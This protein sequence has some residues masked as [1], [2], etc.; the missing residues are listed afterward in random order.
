MV[1]STLLSA[2]VLGRGWRVAGSRGTKGW[3]NSAKDVGSQPAPRR[4]RHAAV[5]NN[6]L[7]RRGRR[8]RGSPGPALPDRW[9]REAKRI[10]P[11]AAPALTKPIAILKARN[12]S[13]L[14]PL[15]SFTAAEALRKAAIPA[16]RASQALLATRLGL[17][18]IRQGRSADRRTG[19]EIQIV[20]PDS[21]DMLIDPRQSA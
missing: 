15:Q 14:A 20:L 18:R 5:Q 12:H 9:Q 19:F 21:G 2:G 7:L 13:G 3:W 11:P 1:S 8:C 10:E 4:H 17:I 6:R 16:A